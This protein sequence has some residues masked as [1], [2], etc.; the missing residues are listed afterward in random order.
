MQQ[1]NLH[2]SP[3]AKTVSS[4]ASVPKS[5]KPQSVSVKK[6]RLPGSKVISK[7]NL[8]NCSKVSIKS[9][10]AETVRGRNTGLS[11]PSL[12]QRQSSG[13]GKSDG[14]SDKP[15]VSQPITDRSA[16]AIR[17]AR[18][19]H[20]VTFDLDSSEKGASDPSARTSEENQRE[21]KSDKTESASKP[22]LG[23]NRKKEGRK[24]PRVQK[25]LRFLKH[26]ILKGGLKNSPNEDAFAFSLEVRP[27]KVLGKPKKKK[28]VVHDPLECFG[29]NGLVP[30]SQ[31]STNLCSDNPEVRGQMQKTNLP[32]GSRLLHPSIRS[33]SQDSLG[34][35]GRRFIRNIKFL[36]EGASQGGFQIKDGSVQSQEGNIRGTA[37]KETI[38]ALFEFIDRRKRRFR[39]GRRKTNEPRKVESV[40]L[41]QDEKKCQ[42][43]AKVVEKPAVE[44]QPEKSY[45]KHQTLTSAL[46]KQQQRQVLK[47]GEGVHGENALE[48]KNSLARP[49]APTINEGSD[50]DKEEVEFEGLAKESQKPLSVPARPNKTRR[51]RRQAGRH[52]TKRSSP[53][54]SREVT[55]F[56]PQAEP[57][58]RGSARDLETERAVVREDGGDGASFGAT[59][60]QTKGVGPGLVSPQRV[61][62]LQASDNNCNSLRKAEPLGDVTP[63]EMKDSDM[64][65][66]N[67]NTAD[68]VSSETDSKQTHCKNV[69]GKGGI[70]PKKAPAPAK[71]SFRY[72]ESGGKRKVVFISP[73]PTGVVKPT[74]G[75][76]N[77]KKKSSK[78]SNDIPSK[79]SFDRAA[80]LSNASSVVELSTAP[81]STYTMGRS[82]SNSFTQAH[83]ASTKTQTHKS[84]ASDNAAVERS[85]NNYVVCSTTLQKKSTPDSAKN[86]NT[87][88]NMVRRRANNSS[89]GRNKNVNLNMN[90]DEAE[91]AEGAD[92]ASLRSSSG[93]GRDK[94]GEEEEHREE[95]QAREEEESDMQSGTEPTATATS[96]KGV[97]SYGRARKVRRKQKPNAE[98]SS[99]P[100]PTPSR[101]VVKSQSRRKPF[102]FK[103][104]DMGKE[105]AAHTMTEL[106]SHTDIAEMLLKVGRLACTRPF[107]LV[108]FAHDTWFATLR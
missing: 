39:V 77:L 74:P 6:K 104:W 103:G 94:A 62:T 95:E 80:G 31:S 93:A 69:G 106:P 84:P 30:R 11:S 36:L 92:A 79:Q 8:D 97:R 4:S 19:K 67:H 15:K 61:D 66:S 7:R 45:G 38:P 32:G 9:G 57:G 73:Q 105:L 29:A 102:T 34:N 40:A 70:F 14:D 107:F 58:D 98:Y 86:S 68:S 24:A 28:I 83:K 71:D 46:Q 41:N 3:S 2:Q 16:L 90:S 10:K 5:L 89:S 108:S 63:V 17:S 72:K 43:R 42:T 33:R 27:K 53:S 44:Q 96:N 1:Q 82:M 47:A 37:E 75:Q 78:R 23:A 52:Q 35:R 76:S 13:I 91:K 48:V 56:R 18:H 60:P 59:R 88:S 85:N 54:H 49:S 26:R 65:C 20:H 99:T 81:K 101:P 50:G 87:N 21:R 25:K 55:E 22:K 51:K 64:T 12:K 100:T